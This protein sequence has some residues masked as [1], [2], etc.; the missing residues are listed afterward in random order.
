[1]KVLSSSRQEFFMFEIPPP[2]NRRKDTLL[3]WFAN[4]IERKKKKLRSFSTH[5]FCKNAA[6]GQI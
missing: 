4:S 6:Y 1:M 2:E 5:G 3:G